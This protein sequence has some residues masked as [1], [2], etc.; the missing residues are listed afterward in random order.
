M[1]AWR[2]TSGVTS[3]LSPNQNASTS[4]RPDAGIGDFADLGGFEVVDGLAHRSVSLRVQ[5]RC[6]LQL[7]G[8]SARLAG[9]VFTTRKP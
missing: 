2:M 1:A 6:I 9:M 4:L 8:I 5:G 3:S 7:V